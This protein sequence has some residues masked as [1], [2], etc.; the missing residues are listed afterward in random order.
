LY[1]E[2]YNLAVLAVKRVIFSIKKGLKGCVQV[3]FGKK[4][5]IFDDVSLKMG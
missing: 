2:W 4:E 3:I 1:L 5:M